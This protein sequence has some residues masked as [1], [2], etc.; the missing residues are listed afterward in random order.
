VANQTGKDRGR[1]DAL[2]VQGSIFHEAKQSP[3]RGKAGVEKIKKKNV[4]V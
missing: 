4:D 3:Q 2:H 1:E